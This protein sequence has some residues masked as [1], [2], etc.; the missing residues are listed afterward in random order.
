MFTNRQI[1][2]F[3]S[4]THHRIFFSFCFINDKKYI[5][6][7]RNRL[8]IRTL[9]VRKVRMHFHTNTGSFEKAGNNLINLMFS[10]LSH[11]SIYLFS[12]TE[13]VFYYFYK[14][15]SLNKKCTILSTRPLNNK[16]I[17]Q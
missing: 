13:S 3:T 11:F 12:T 5:Y 6:L 17:N 16:Q 8:I 9:K 14:S 7:H 10:F 1:E 4:I 2:S 15:L